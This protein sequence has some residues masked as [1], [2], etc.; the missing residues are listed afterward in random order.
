ML[1]CVRAIEKIV[2]ELNFVNDNSAYVVVRIENVLVEVMVEEGRD[3]LLE[4]S[5]VADSHASRGSKMLP[6]VLHDSQEA[7]VMPQT[8]FFGAEMVKR[9]D[10]L[11]KSD[12]ESAVG[13][14]GGKAVLLVH[15]GDRKGARF[16]RVYAGTH[17]PIVFR[18]DSWI[19]R[20]PSQDIL[21]V[22]TLALEN[23]C[24]SLDFLRNWYPP[25]APLYRRSRFYGDR[26]SMKRLF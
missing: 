14:L 20:R 11:T 25:L 24:R 15:M 9:F 21:P 12:L 13:D 3:A 26:W 19:L 22:L 5:S 6:Y 18:E 23:R 2:D 16:P 4:N 1:P 10:A 8:H 17:Q 7:L